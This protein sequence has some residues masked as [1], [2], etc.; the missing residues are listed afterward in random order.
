M[1]DPKRRLVRGGQVYDHDGNVHKP[2]VADILIEDG[3]IIAVGPDLPSEG[4]QDIIDARDRLVVPGL[5]NAHY[6]PTT[7][8]AKSGAATETWLLYTADSNR[9]RG[10]APAPGRRRRIIAVRHTTAGHAVV[11]L[12]EPSTDVG[13]AYRDA[14]IRVVFSPMVWD[15]PP[16]AMVRNRD[17]LPPDVQGMLGTTGRPVRDQLDYLE[18]QFNRHPAAGTLHWAVAP[19]APQRCTPKMLQG[20]A[21][22]AHKT[23]RGL[24]SRL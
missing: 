17:N 13:Q 10:V 14:G 6:H 5:I 3:N 9:R 23:I 11:P 18:H 22:L 21:D 4:V 12:D 19:F 20:C 24:H 7:R 15:I 8:A 16:I 2:S 1:A